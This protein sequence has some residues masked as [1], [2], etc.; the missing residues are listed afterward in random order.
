MTLL[1][2][3][4]KLGLFILITLVYYAELLTDFS[5]TNLIVQAIEMHWTDSCLFEDYLL[6]NEA[7]L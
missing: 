1:I 5:Y 2:Y 3:N 4:L 6:Y 7:G